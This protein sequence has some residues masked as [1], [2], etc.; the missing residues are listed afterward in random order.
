MPNIKSAAQYIGV[1]YTTIS[2][3]YTTGISYDNYLY[4]FEPKDIKVWIY[5]CENEFIEILDNAN[6][7]SE[8]IITLNLLYLITL[9]QENFTKKVLILWY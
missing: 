1:E 8:N 5:N 9:N 6:K 2:R 4:E 7:T 3:I